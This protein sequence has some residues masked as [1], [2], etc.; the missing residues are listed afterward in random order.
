M[1]YVSEV[2]EF[3]TIVFGLERYQAAALEELWFGELRE[4]DESKEELID[5][6]NVLLRMCGSPSYVQDVMYDESERAYNWA[7]TRTVH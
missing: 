2:N 7:L 3:D 5:A 6:A 1:E 4:F